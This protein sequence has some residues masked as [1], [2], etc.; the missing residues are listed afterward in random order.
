LQEICT[1]EP[2]NRTD[3]LTAALLSIAAAYPTPLYVYDLDAVRQRI[4]AL[5]NVLGGRFEIS[6]A[7]KANPNRALLKAIA[8]RVNN[9]DASSYKEVERVSEVAADKTITF[10]G[11]GKRDDELLRFARRGGGELVLESVEEAESLS[12]AIAAHGLGRQP[13][14]VRV[15]PA[16]S[17]RHFGASMSSKRSQFGIDE[18][19]IESVLRAITA[20]PG[21]QLIGFH[22]YTATNSLNAEAIGENVRIM[23][24]LFRRCVEL[25]G[26]DPELLI[27]GA[28]FGLPY[29]ENEKEL[30]IDAVAAAVVP[31]ADELRSEARFRKTRLVFELG[32]WL[33]GPAGYLL[34]SV[35]RTKTSRG[36]AIRICDAGFN[37]HMAACGMLGGLFKRNWRI[38]NLSNPNGTPETCD[39]V[40]PLCTSIDQVATGIVLPQVRTGDVLMI[41]YSGAYGL[42]ASPTRFIS[43]PEPKEIAILD[44]QIRDVT[45]SSLNW[46]SS[47]T[48]SVRPTS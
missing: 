27:F 24:D 30:D 39:L 14:I 17:P 11:P 9:F 41:E 18:D 48:E 32:R 34:T 36:T 28:G 22:S 2:A 15:N 31:M 44:G 7:V 3:D 35:I 46:W 40:G 33:V 23:I 1:A 42:T 38:R 45:E 12:K 19:Q 20:L 37:A 43:H 29:F 25:C 4:D 5:R 47:P 6:Y 8:P 21:L 16:R 13:V 10:T 26:I